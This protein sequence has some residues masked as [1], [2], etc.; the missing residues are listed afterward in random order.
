MLNLLLAL[1]GPVDRPR[2]GR[3]MRRRGGAARSNSQGSAEY[4]V[5]QRHGVVCP[6]GTGTLNFTKFGLGN[7]ISRDSEHI[8]CQGGNYPLENPELTGQRRPVPCA[9]PIKAST[10]ATVL[11]SMR[12]STSYSAS[13]SLSGKPMLPLLTN[14]LFCDTISLST[15]IFCIAQNNI[16]GGCGSSEDAAT[17][18]IHN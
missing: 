8:M 4:L 11:R 7:I 2:L 14:I 16:C 9:E 18:L 15:R 17:A 1:T 10:T 6:S 13:R 5:S 12:G 3:T